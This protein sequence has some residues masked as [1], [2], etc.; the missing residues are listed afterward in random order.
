[1][2]IPPAAIDTGNWAGYEWRGGSTSAAEFVVPEFPFHDMS[3]AEKENRT[4]MS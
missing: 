3:V 2:I 4:V 1:M